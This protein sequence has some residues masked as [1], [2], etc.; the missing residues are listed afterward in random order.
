MHVHVWLNFVHVIK[1]TLRL[2]IS[3]QGL[4]GR[5]KLIVKYIGSVGLNDTNDWSDNYWTNLI[6][7]SIII[8]KS[9]SQDD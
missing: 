7:I 1:Y 3:C 8:T 5:D 6:G 9:L 4:G 2:L